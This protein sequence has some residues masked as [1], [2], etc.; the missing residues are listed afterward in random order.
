VVDHH[1]ED[2][3]D[4]ERPPILRKAVR[5]FDQVDQ[6]VLR[7]EPRVDAQVVV[8]VVTVVGVLVVLEDR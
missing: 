2:D 6:V 4:G 3:P 8:D 7:A 1:V 5:R